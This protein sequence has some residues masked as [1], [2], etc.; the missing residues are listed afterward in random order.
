MRTCTLAQI[1]ATTSSGC[2]RKRSATSSL[3]SRN[4]HMLPKLVQSDLQSHQRRTR[5][6]ERKKER[7]FVTS[8]L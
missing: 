6:Q 7:T 2:E 1:T 3:L 5:A 8:I 4:T